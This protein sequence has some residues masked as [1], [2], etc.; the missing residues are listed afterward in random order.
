M[1]RSY[2]PNGFR[3]P[4]LSSGKEWV[5]VHRGESGDEL[6]RRSD[7][8]AY[9][10]VSRGKGVSLLADE[11]QRTAWL[12]TFDLGSPTVLDWMESED[13]ACFVTSTVAGV[14]ADQLDADDL[15]RAWPS[16]AECVRELHGIPADECPFERGLQTMFDRAK[17]V[18]ARDAVNPDFL[19]PDL[20]DIPAETLLAH[21]KAELPKRL[22][23]EA[24]DLVV[25]HGDACMPNFMVDPET[26][27]CTGLIDLGRLGTAD[28]Y[29]DFALLVGNTRETWT[30]S[31]QAEAAHL[32]LFD[33][34]H[35][36]NPDWGRLGFY[37]RLDPLTWG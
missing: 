19:D 30:E 32:R 3:L 22:E 17:D 20:K 5:P 9:A 1:N 2:R 4:G 13:A 16:I 33:I 14:P 24:R 29:V 31:E 23:Q 7:G 11:Y 21:L 18:V 10:K 6:F 27:R 25:C 28:R 26:L 8:A 37:L 34:H 12:A 36:A 15:A 35:I